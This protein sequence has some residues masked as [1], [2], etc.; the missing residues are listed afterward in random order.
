MAV[1]ISPSQNK[2]YYINPAYLTFNENSGYGVNLIQVSAS[3]S[4]YITVYDPDNGIRYNVESGYR[5]WKIT[6]YNN[7][8]PS[9]KPEYL[10]AW[11]IYIRLERNGSS[12]LVVYDQKS[13]A[14]SGGIITVDEEGK[15]TVGEADPDYYYIH[16]GT[17]G[18]TDGVST[19]RQITYDTGYLDTPESQNSAW[20][21]LDA[22][23][24]PHY[25]DPNNPG[26]L[27]WIEAKSNMGVQGGVTMFIDD[28]PFQMPTVMDAIQ[29]DGK[30]IRVNPET[31][32]LE[33]VACP[34][35][36]GGEPEPGNPS[37]PDDSGDSSADGDKTFR[38]GQETSSDEWMIE[39]NLNKYPSVMVFDSAGDE[40]HGDIV[41]I[42]ANVV[43]LNF[44]AAF[45]GY[46]ILN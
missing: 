42:N 3:S 11:N 21:L 43:T 25:D 23:F 34:G 17:V 4:C 12:A 2:T 46:A 14:I 16:I 37:V 6:A 9:D 18:A 40:V 20:D 15:N 27:S 24:T 7:L 36:E 38:Y 29:T 22:M 28:S 26:K 1:R 8:F 45:S 10:E 44:S 32:Q 41:Y 19:I 13:R 35:V 39:H 33:V 5:K 30:T 31:K